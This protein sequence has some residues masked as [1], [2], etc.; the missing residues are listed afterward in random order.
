M[1]VTQ[2]SFEGKKPWVNITFLFWES[3]P[4]S[5]VGPVAISRIGLPPPPPALAD[6]GRHQGSEQH[7]DRFPIAAFISYTAYSQFTIKTGHLL[8]IY[9]LIYL[10]LGCL[11]LFG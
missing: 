2:C 9:H 5:P 11:V 7:P 8:I 3:M 1:L 10:L 6:A 4:Y